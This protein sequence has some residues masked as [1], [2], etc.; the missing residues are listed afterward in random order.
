MHRRGGLVKIG[1]ILDNFTLKEVAPMAKKP[2]PPVDTRAERVIALEMLVQ[3]GILPAIQL[4]LP[5]F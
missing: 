2:K 1:P 3:A 4:R 5:G